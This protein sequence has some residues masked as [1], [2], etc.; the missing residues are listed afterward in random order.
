[1]R[2][3]SKFHNIPILILLLTVFP[4][5]IVVS[6]QDVTAPTEIK[7][8]PRN[9]GSEQIFTPTKIIVVKLI[10]RITDT[11]KFLLSLDNLFIDQLKQNQNLFSYIFADGHMYKFHDLDTTYSSNAKT[12]VTSEIGYIGDFPAQDIANLMSAFKIKNIS[13]GKIEFNNNLFN[14]VEIQNKFPSLPAANNKSNVSEVTADYNATP[15]PASL[16]NVSVKFKNNTAYPIYHG[17]VSQ[18]VALSLEKDKE[19]ASDFFVND[20]W[21]SPSRTGNFSETRIGPG[22]FGTLIFPIVVPADAEVKT[23]DFVLGQIDGKT[24]ANTT[25]Q[26]KLSIPDQKQKLISVKNN[27]L[28]FVGVHETAVYNAKVLG[29]VNAGTHL[30]ILQDN[31]T[32]LKVRF[33][34]DKEG[35]LQSSLITKLP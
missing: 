33:Q 14:V 4:I 2:R 13:M 28:G 11:E 9:V 6:A 24:F 15:D 35:W 32:W 30:I 8:S 20:K 21:Y 22:E 10:P 12:G 34:G 1:L 19:K 26:I 16:I 25:F 29:F 5:G 17:D 7:F 31:G 23:Q 18:V 27:Y 3:F